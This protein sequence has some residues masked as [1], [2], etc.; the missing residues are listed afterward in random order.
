MPRCEGRAIY[1]S[2]HNISIYINWYH[3]NIKY[4]I[5]PRY[6]GRAI[7]PTFAF[8]SH[9][10]NPNART[11]IQVCICILVQYDIKWYCLRYNITQHY[12]FCI[13]STVWH[14]MILFKIL[15]YDITWNHIMC[16]DNI[17][18]VG[19]RDD[20][21]VCSEGNQ[22]GRRGFHWNNYHVGTLLMNQHQL[23]ISSLSSFLT[24]MRIMRMVS[25][26]TMT[27][28]QVVITYTSLMTSLPRRQD[29]LACLW[30]F[31]CSCPR[32]V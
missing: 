13:F 9:S 4:K 5:V 7:Y 17:S 14:Q 12:T 8:M 16:L 26:V 28:K 19:G 31:T 11:V 3:I 30:F 1:L 32:S 15:R 20:A 21:S 24:T 6:E 22:E 10:C 27:H 25:M 2:C 23:V 18:M 29:K